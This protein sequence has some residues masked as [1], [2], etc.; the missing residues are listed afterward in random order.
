MSGNNRNSH[1]AD[2][3][4]PIISDRQ[5]LNMAFEEAIRSCNSSRASVRILEAGCGKSWPLKLSDLNVQLVGVDNNQHALDNR[6]NGVG[7]L[8]EAICGDISNVKLPEDSFDVVYCSYVLEHVQGAEFALLN[9]VKWIRPGGIMIVKVPDGES[10]FGFASRVTPF[11]VH[12]LYKRYIARNPNAGRKGHEP[13]PTVFDPVVSRRGLTRFIKENE[14]I[15]VMLCR[16]NLFPLR[17]K[18]YAHLLWIGCIQVISL[19]SLRRL[20][21]DHSGLAVVLQKSE[22]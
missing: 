22:S 11:W 1:S 5:K 3:D 9:F 12:M 10:A 15:P 18:R 8:A 14:L 16:T 17:I 4:W 6:I 19:L 13:F 7:D 2:S 21:T 20:S